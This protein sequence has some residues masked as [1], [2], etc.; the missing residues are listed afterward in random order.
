L[1]LA[2]EDL[3]EKEAKV[4]NVKAEGEES[5]NRG[6]SAPRRAASEIEAD[7]KGGSG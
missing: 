6:W 5:P 3:E 4:K 1:D 7:G 2:A